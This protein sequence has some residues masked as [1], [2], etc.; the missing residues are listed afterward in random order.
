MSAVERA[1]EGHGCTVLVSGE[2]GIGKT[3]VVRAFLAA[4]GGRARVLAGSCEDLLT[5]RAFG[6]LRDAVRG[7]RGPLADALA[8]PADLDAVFGAVHEEL[9]DTQRPTVLV[10]EDVHW[11]DGA[12]L[13]VLRYVGRRATSVRG[14]GAHLPRR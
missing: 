3:S 13:D 6:P 14:A 1:A 10:M 11:S 9:A 5:A 2:A 8:G 4:L 12:T 7:T